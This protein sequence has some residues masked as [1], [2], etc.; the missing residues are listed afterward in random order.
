MPAIA[1][2]WYE[3][4]G[5]VWI[6]EIQTKEIETLSYKEFNQDMPLTY[7][8]LLGPQEIPV[9]ACTLE[10]DGGIRPD[11]TPWIGGLVVNTKYQKQGIGKR[12]LNT[13]VRKA[14][15]FGFKKVYLFTFE[16]LIASY[17]E[18]FGWEKIGVDILDL[19]HNPKI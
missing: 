7:I 8:A 3:V 2:I 14:E 18:R 9:G 6:P 1:N 10:L 12:L 5:K 13:A 11:L 15:E 4:L 17:Y 16:Q 19:L